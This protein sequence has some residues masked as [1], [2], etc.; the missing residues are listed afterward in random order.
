MTSI[1]KWPG[2]ATCF[3]ND[4]QALSRIIDARSGEKWGLN[5]YTSR[6]GVWDDPEDFD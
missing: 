4:H 6:K 2:I 1:R 3:F 5:D